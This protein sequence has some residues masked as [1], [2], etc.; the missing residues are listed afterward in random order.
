MPGTPNRW[1]ILCCN[2]NVL[3]S[4]KLLLRNCVEMYVYDTKCR[5]MTVP[6]G[7]VYETMHM[8][9]CRCTYRRL[10]HLQMRSC[11]TT[12]YKFVLLK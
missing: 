10:H 6:E 8:S 3:V 4:K 7:R 9:T 2:I 12:F 11:L 5:P 1:K